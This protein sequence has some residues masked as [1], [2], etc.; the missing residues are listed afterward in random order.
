MYAVTRKHTHY[1]LAHGKVQERGLTEKKPIES[2][3]S[4]APE[5]NYSFYGYA[6]LWQFVRMIQTF[7]RVV[8]VLE[9]VCMMAVYARSVKGKE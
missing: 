3:E 8:L 4:N 6:P 5:N 7:V 1:I 2:K 9:R